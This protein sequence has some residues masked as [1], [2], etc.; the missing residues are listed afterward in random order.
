[1]RILLYSH[2]FAPAVGGV[3]TCGILLAEG[4]ASFQGATAAGETFA[5]T[6]VT[7]T[8]GDGFDESRLPFTVVR[9][10][11]FWQLVHLIQAADLV[12]LAGPCFLPLAICWLIRKPVVVVHHG[13]QSICPNGL[14]FKQPSQSMCPGHFMKR[15]Y[16]QCLNCCAQV[17]GTAG[18]VRSLLLTFSRRWL[19]KRMAVNISVTKHLEARI[20]LPRARTIYHGVPVVEALEPPRTGSPPDVIEF[21]YVGRLVAEKGLSLLLHAAEHIASQGKHFKLTFIGDGPERTR[22]EQMACD[23]RLDELV[24]FTGVLRGAALDRAVS[25]VSVVVM[26]SIW[27]ETAGLGAIEQM[28][29]GRLVIA[30][31][32]GG[33]GEVVGDAGLKFAPGDFQSLASCMQIA[34]DNREV[35]ASLGSEAR[36][37]AVARFRHEGMIESHAALCSE[38]L[39]R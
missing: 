19:C 35:V 36:R 20:H 18:S 25:R 1:M 26:P 27:E 31:D 23:L 8:P 34:L 29:R 37:R 10:P 32:I 7:A 21:A 14:L 16:G 33:L 39:G 17:V 11:G 9:R 3:E 28:M 13:Y 4:L 15:Q 38:V 30:A 6:V 12:H 5:V 24:R 22:L 2:S